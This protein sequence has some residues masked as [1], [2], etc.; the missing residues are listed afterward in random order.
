[1]ASGDEEVDE[2]AS[3]LNIP[4]H[5]FDLIIAD[6]CHRGY[7]TQESAIW[8]KTL[9]HFDCVKV[10]LTATP[11][12]HTMAYFK[13]IGLQPPA[14]AV[15][16]GAGAAEEGGLE[17]PEPAAASCV[18]LAA[19]RL[20]EISR[21]HVAT[22]VLRSLPSESKPTSLKPQPQP[23]G[24]IRRVASRSSSRQLRCSAC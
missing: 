11:A 9:D 6:E 24:I 22:E 14:S 10:G 21:R 4:I 20:L 16:E 8:R 15:G 19:F 1:M 13:D 17:Q 18:R 3:Q 23:C 5:A 12:A 2:D 7:S